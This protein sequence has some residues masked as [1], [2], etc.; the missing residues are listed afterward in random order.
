MGQLIPKPESLAK[1]VFLVRGER[2]MLDTDLAAL[3]AVEARALNQAVARNRER[4]PEDFMFQLSVE[5][6]AALRSQIVTTAQSATANSSQTVMSS[7]KHRGLAYRPYAFTEQ[8]VAMLS[9][10]LRS[11]RAV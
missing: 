9:S 11:Q 4:F 5:E 6:W 2:V 3:Y 1:L 7:R 8:G 10:V